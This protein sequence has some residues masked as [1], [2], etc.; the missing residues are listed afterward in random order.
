MGFFQRLHV[1]I[2]EHSYFCHHQSTD[3]VCTRDLTPAVQEKLSAIQLILYVSLPE[4]DKSEN[5][6]T[7]THTKSRKWINILFIYHD[8]FIYI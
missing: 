5:T 4:T 3:I 6:H 7:N 8:Y 2:I 1:S